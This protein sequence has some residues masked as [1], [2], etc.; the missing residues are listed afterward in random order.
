MT[1]LLAST[2]TALAVTL[3]AP[4]LAPAA[5]ATDAEKFDRAV[6]KFVPSFD[7]L[8]LDKPF[9]PKT[10]CVCTEAPRKA[11]FLHRLPDGSVLCGI[12]VF[13]PDGGFA[14]VAAICN[15]FEIL[16]K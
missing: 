16:S 2:L 3:A 11:G 15:S 6:A 4:T 8:F 14:D 12:P 10:L 9:K 5:Q 1:R 7:D 13:L